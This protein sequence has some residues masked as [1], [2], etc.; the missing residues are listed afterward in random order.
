MANLTPTETAELQKLCTTAGIIEAQEKYNA[1]REAA[2][3]FL[4]SDAPEE[5]KDALR[6]ALNSG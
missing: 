6:K 1:L 3:P 5:L 2:E 4:Y